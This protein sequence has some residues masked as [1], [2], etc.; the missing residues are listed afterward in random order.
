MLYSILLLFG[1]SESVHRLK[2]SAKDSESNKGH[3]KLEGLHICFL[4]QVTG[5]KT[6]WTGGNYWCKA[7]AESLLQATGT[8][9]LNNYIE[10][11]Q[12]EVAERVALRHIFEVCKKYT[13]YEG[14]G[15]LQDPWWRQAASE[16][17]LKATLKIFCQ[18]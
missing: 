4:R 15:M 17:Q 5:Q 18:H 7:A 12:V 8:K 11:R 3:H 1:L 10:N 9:I 13:G 6:R 14:G 16:Q 2:I